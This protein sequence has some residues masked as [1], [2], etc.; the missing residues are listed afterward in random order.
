VT[1]KNKKRYYLAF[2]AVESN[3]TAADNC[4]FATTAGISA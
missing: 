4:Q 1:F 2:Q 3:W